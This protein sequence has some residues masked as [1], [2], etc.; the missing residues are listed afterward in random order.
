MFP[1]W[2]AFLSGLAGALLNACSAVRYTRFFLGAATAIVF[3][4][5]SVSFLVSLAPFTRERDRC[6]QVYT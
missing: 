6:A 5:I 4:L 2:I 1:S 3:V